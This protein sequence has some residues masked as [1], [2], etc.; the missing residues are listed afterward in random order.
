MPKTKREKMKNK[1]RA[2]S[3]RKTVAC[4]VSAFLF[5]AFLPKSHVLASSTLTH[6]EGGFLVPNKPYGWSSNNKP[7]LKMQTVLDSANMLITPVKSCQIGRNVIRNT[8]QGFSYTASF[9]VLVLTMGGRID[10]RTIRIHKY[11]RG[12]STS[13]DMRHPNFNSI[14][15]EVLTSPNGQ[16]IYRYVLGPDG[17]P[18]TYDS[19]LNVSQGTTQRDGSIVVYPNSPPK[20]DLWDNFSDD[21][22]RFLASVMPVWALKRP[23]LEQVYASFYDP[24]AGCPARGTQSYNLATHNFPT[25]P[26]NGYNHSRFMDYLRR[27]TLL[28]SPATGSV[29]VPRHIPREFIANLVRW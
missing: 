12:F 28:M 4:I 10:D 5:L 2:K 9:M 17:R 25:C 21:E 22:V 29:C 20:P 8:S 18:Y 16:L 19:Y 14:I 24:P 11:E 13:F 6:V 23:E 7:V 26:V 27:N 3:L 15:V 1:A